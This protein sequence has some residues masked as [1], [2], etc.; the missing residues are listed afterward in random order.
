MNQQKAPARDVSPI[1]SAMADVEH[2]SR[3]LLEAV[4]VLTSRLEP[5]MLPLLPA[6]ASAEAK[7]ERE[8][9]S[10]LADQLQNRADF[11]RGIRDYL[12]GVLR[13]LEV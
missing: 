12:I 11:L 8:E 4:H 10:P 6:A 5:V 9:R 2:A 3:E 13:R 1:D 7:D